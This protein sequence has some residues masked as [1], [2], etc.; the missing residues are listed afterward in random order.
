MVDALKGVFRGFDIATAGLRAELQ[1]SEIVSANLVNMHRTGNADKAP[2]RRQIA[3]F[4][5]VLDAAVQ[6]RGGIGGSGAR[7]GRIAE[8]QTPFP[9]FYQPGHPDADEN[10]MVLGSNVE[11]FQELADM[12]V[13]SRSVDAN[14]AAMRTYRSMLQNV[15]QNMGK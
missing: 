12:Q 6:D 15:V 14:L 2:Y 11:L 1:R 3:M 13:I 10:G 4:E 7:I 8:D 5:E 9:T